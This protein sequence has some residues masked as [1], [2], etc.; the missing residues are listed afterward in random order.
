MLIY[1]N[2]ILYCKITSGGGYDEDGN[3]VAVVE[4]WGEAVTCHIDTA[5][6]SNDGYYDNGNFTKAQYVV[7]IENQPFDAKRIKLTLDG[8][9]LG[10][11]LVQDVQ[12]K[13]INKK[14]QI[15]V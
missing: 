9:D 2:G 12:I 11:F 3:P 14:I 8:G 1:P 10:E 15:M 6:H 7:F 13:H 5:S 4:S